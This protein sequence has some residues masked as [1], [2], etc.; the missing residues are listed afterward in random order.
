MS[1]GTMVMLGACIAGFLTLD[2]ALLDRGLSLALPR[3]FVRLLN[4]LAV[5]R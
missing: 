2:A 1:S 5:W 3:H 4:R